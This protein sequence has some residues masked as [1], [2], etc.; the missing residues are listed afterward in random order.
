MHIDDDSDDRILFKQ[1]LK[2]LDSD[3]RYIPVGDVDEA[4]DYLNR[5]NGSAFFPDVIF[6]DINMP[7]KNGW[8]CLAELKKSKTLSGIPVAMYSTTWTEDLLKKAVSLGAVSLIQ[9]PMYFDDI[10]KE[11]KKLISTLKLNSVSPSVHPDS[12]G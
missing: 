3:L 12:G 1:A 6:L 11:I 8:Q 2:E 9:K 4:L 10:V 7:R 5:L